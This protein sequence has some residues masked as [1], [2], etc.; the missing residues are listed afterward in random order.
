MLSL[1]Q[2]G[3]DMVYYPSPNIPGDNLRYCVSRSLNL[4][5]PR[6]DRLPMLTPHPTC[7]L[8]SDITAGTL[9]W[10]PYLGCDTIQGTEDPRPIS[11]LRV[12]WDVRGVGMES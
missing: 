8:Q 11:A 9:Y 2:M 5:D 10:R 12:G 7:A 3:A 4:V 1:H 6:L